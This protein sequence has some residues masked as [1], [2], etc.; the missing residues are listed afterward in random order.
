MEPT[1]GE[2][3]TA[4]RNADQ[5]GDIEAATRLAQIA[6]QLMQQKP[7]GS[8]AE[9]ALRNLP[10]STANLLGD[11]YTA[12]T[13]PLQT[14]KSVL[15]LGAGI[16]QSIAPESL[17]Q[18][19]G[20]DKP[21]REV[22]RKVGQFYANRYGSV[23][24]AKKAIAEDPAGVMAD[25]ATVLYGGGAAMRVTPYL[26][27][28]TAQVG[29]IV[30]K[31]GSYVDPLS[32]IGKGVKGAASVITPVI[33]QTTGAGAESIRQAYRAG[34]EGG[35]RATQ[36]RE[37]LTGRANPQDILDA[38]KQNLNALREQ[39][40][41]RYRSGMVDITKDKSQL[42]FDGIDKA[43]NAAEGRT[44]FKQKVTDAA[45]FNELTKARE[46]VEEWKASDPEIY[47]TPEGLDALKQ[48]VGAILDGL[49]PGK[50][51]YNTVN[52]VYNSI[53]SEIV[54]QAP[55]YANTMRD[56]M[57]STELIREAEKA[58][59]LN[60]KASADTALRKLLSLVRDNVQTNYGA[61]AKTAQQLEEAGGRMMMPSIAGQ[62]LQSFVPRGIQGATALPAG[63]I[64][65]MAGGPVMAG[66]SLA[67]SSPRLMG[68]AAYGAGLASR[69]LGPVQR[70]APFMLTPELY[71]LL[72]QSGELQSEPLRIDV[73]TRNR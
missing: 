73:T 66:A 42:S 54:K 59:S 61:R 40:G 53:K 34:Q 38:A 55:V 69:A 35:E 51:P 32:L 11:L 41:E 19:I 16:L 39:R 13:N 47:H 57:Q 15:D 31:V 67:A 65:Y 22:A 68:E 36:F 64:S 1:L 27:P 62:A 4:L 44:K 48:S 52:Q 49:D 43:L 24:G 12:I 2:V 60:N 63:G 33:G 14:A 3:M 6:N 30:S 58:L 25:L 37:S 23:E 18:M 50:N 5:A 9:Q 72:T 21:S 28:K 45:A 8:V 7:K 20:E 29:E 17:V 71:N 70:Q 10:S 26:T 56:Y 46:L